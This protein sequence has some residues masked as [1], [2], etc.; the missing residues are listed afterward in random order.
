VSFLERFE[1]DPPSEKIAAGLNVEGRLICFHER[2]PCISR[3]GIYWDGEKM[4][5]ISKDIRLDWLAR[6]THLHE[7]ELLTSN[8]LRAV[9]GLY[10]LTKEWNDS[11]V[12]TSIRL[13][14]R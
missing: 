11:Y 14:M 8:A 5:P 4:K 12:P 9:C 10:R 7:P 6:L 2:M 3:C 1:V 13:R